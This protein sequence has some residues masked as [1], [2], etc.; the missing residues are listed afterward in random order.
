MTSAPCSSCTGPL[1]AA[2]DVELSARLTSLAPNVG[3]PAYQW[4]N[5]PPTAAGLMIR[6][7]LT[8]KCGRFLLIQIEASG[9]LV[10]R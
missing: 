2:G 6:E 10:C 1:H 7:S 8:E 5:T 3:G 4:D 9:S